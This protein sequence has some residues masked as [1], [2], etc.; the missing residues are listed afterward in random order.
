MF[1]CIGAATPGVSVRTDGV[2]TAEMLIAAG[3]AVRAVGLAN[4]R[5]PLSI[6]VPCHRVIGSN[7]ALTGYGGGLW[8][9]QWLLAHER[10][11]PANARPYASFMA[12]KS[13][14]SSVR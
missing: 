5:N 2:E 4:G 10:A 7:G 14:P 1:A 9:K 6:I 13:P 3:V 11:A 12:G 8:R